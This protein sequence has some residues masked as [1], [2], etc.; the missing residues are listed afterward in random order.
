MKYLFFDIDG[1]LV[2]EHKHLPESTKRTLERLKENGHFIAIATSRP[3]VLTYLQ[4]EALN[5]ENYVCDGG[6][7][8]VINNTIIELLPL[9]L[10]DCLAVAKECLI[11]QIPIATSIDTTNNRYSTDGKFIA[12]NRSLENAFDF[13]TKTDFDVLQAKTIHKMCLHLTL[14]EESLIPSLKK[15]PHYRI[16]P[17]CILVEAIDK[18]RGI[19][20]MVDY[21]QGNH[22]EIIVFGDGMNDIKMFEQAPY[23]VAM[24]NAAEPLK[25]IAS[26]ITEDIHADGIEKACKHLGLI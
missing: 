22:Q 7:G 20:K 21:L 19:E 23:S 9:N 4:A 10:E 3:Y 12:L 24:G 11:H 16:S 15:V 26:Y 1:T 8:L 17:T 13:V 6:D 25:K 14:K 2:D 18:Y 5:I